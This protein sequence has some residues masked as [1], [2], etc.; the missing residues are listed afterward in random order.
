MST[1]DEAKKQLIEM[2]KTMNAQVLCEVPEGTTG[3][4]FQITLSTKDKKL[5]L[6]LSEDDLLDFLEDPGKMKEIR[7]QV[8]QLIRDLRS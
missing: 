3:G 4:L 2:V 7:G 1:I 8:E 5:P 6:P